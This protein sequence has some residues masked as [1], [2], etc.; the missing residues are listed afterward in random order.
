MDSHGG[1]KRGFQAFSVR[2]QERRSLP[3][4]AGRS[5]GTAAHFTG[6]MQVKVKINEI[7]EIKYQSTTSYD[8]GDDDNFF[9]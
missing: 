1:R 5:V 3:P 6:Q 9:I 4:S 2:L 7:N 8:D